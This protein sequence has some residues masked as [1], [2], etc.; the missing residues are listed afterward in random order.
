MIDPALRHLTESFGMA[1]RSLAAGRGPVRDR[2]VGAFHQLGAPEIEIRHVL[3]SEL[4]ES[5]DSIRKRMTST[6]ATSNEG[7]Y[8]AAVN[9]MTEEQATELAQDLFD[10]AWSI[11]MRFWESNTA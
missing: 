7:L 6:P 11:A 1:A 4:Q 10:L 8:Q 5:W 3:D 9:E 2:L